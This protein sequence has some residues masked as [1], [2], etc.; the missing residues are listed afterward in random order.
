[1][2]GLVWIGR[3]ILVGS[4]LMLLTLLAGLFWFITIPLG[5]VALLIAGAKVHRASWSMLRKVN[6]FLDEPVTRR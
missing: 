3:L 6:A 1:M 2:N 4:G 5:L